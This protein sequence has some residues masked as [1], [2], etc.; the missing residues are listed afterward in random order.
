MIAGVVFLVLV[1]LIR[2]RRESCPNDLSG[3]HIVAG[4]TA[5]KAAKMM[6]VLVIIPALL[7][8]V[9]LCDKNGQGRLVTQTADL[10]RCHATGL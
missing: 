7:P 8:M 4:V 1:T 10:R 3:A 6:A 5:N 2:A 9:V